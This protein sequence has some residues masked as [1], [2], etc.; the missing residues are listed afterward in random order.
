MVGEAGVMFPAGL[1]GNWNNFARIVAR[2][3]T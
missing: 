3:D 1:S 2:I